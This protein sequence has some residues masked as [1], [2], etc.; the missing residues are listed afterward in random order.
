MQTKKP[1]QK[2]TKTDEILQKKKV[3]P[4]D[5]TQL[6]VEE[7]KALQNEINKRFKDLKGEEREAFLDKI[8]AIIPE[9][10][11]PYVRNQI[12]EDNHQEIC[13]VISNFIK[14]NGQIPTKYQIAME[15]GLSRQTVYKHL[16]S[17]A[18][19]ELYKE[20][21]S[22]LKILTNKLLTIVYQ[23]ACR[24]NVK[25]ARL[26]FEM[27]GEL[28]CRKTS[29]NNFFIQINSVRVDENL[30]R[31]LPADA[32]NEIEKILCKNLM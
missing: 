32:L 26:Y 13:R 30:I 21:L 11:K 16:S 25:A 12:W 1:L 14:S 8:E 2:L 19:S 31:S 4:S 23:D 10:E 20:E 5:V 15:S 7:W 22:K 29:T 17:F 28:S 18:E 27:T 3:Y 24:G 6:P 9:S